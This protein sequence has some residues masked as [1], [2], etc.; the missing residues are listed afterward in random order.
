MHE[1]APAYHTAVVREADQT[2]QTLTHVVILAAG[3][4][5]REMKSKLPKVL[6]RVGGLA[7]LDHVIRPPRLWLLH[8]DCCSRPRWRASS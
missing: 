6:H 3:Q 7:L 4:G 1:A 8:S 2:G 5:T